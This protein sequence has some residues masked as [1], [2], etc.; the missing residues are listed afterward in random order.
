MEQSSPAASRAPRP[1]RHVAVVASAS[2]AYIGAFTAGALAAPL[3]T[4]E[5]A[6]SGLPNAIGI[7]ATALAASV[8]SMV[9][10][11]RGRR[12]GL[13]LGFGIGVLGGL[14]AMLSLSIG[15]LAVL[16]VASVCLGISNGAIQLTRYAAADAVAPSHR[17]AVIGIVVWGSTVGAV[18]GPN[19]LAPAAGLGATVGLGPLTGAFAFVVA[20]MLVAL[21]I[22][23]TLPRGDAPAEAVGA[24]KASRRDLLAQPHVRLA[25]VGML[26]SQVV[27]VL[28]MTMTPLHVQEMGHGIGAVGIVI[29][30]HTLGMF[31]LSPLSAALVTRLGALRV[32]LVSFAVLGLAGIVAALAP[33]DAVPVLALGLFLLGLG[34][35]FGFVAGSSLLARGAEGPERMTLQGTTD[36]IIWTSAALASIGSGALLEL[37]GYSTLG[38]IATACLVLP[39]IALVIGRQSAAEPTAG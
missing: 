4:G 11:R 38:F 17:A 9:M 30:A 3:L 21:A 36:A 29:S 27:M 32:M 20:G 2:T 31:A 33:N 34:W 5:R 35:S 16:L 25:L 12:F 19:L 6:T 39:A 22:A 18:F 7:A 15:S 8:L 14:A 24:Q 1:F 26:A 37:V 10:A 13:Q 28:V 23:S